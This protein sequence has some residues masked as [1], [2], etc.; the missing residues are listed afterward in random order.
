MKDP[1]SLENNL[2]FLAGEVTRKV[3]NEIKAAFRGA[4]YDIT[5]EQFSI[6]A[7][8]WYE[9]GINQQFL[10]DHLDRDKTTITRVVKNMEKSNLLVR[11]PDQADKRNNLIYLTSKGKEL[12]NDLILLSGKTYVQ[13]LG[14]LPEDNLN[15]AISL[16][17]KILNNLK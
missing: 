17:Q 11:V 6:L 9:E 16:F 13:A 12:Q 4:G 5:V 3:N 2:L 1:K 8:L 10:A 7:V 15:Q 14:N